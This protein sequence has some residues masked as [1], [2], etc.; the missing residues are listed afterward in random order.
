MTYK[1]PRARD[2]SGN[3]LRS[4]R[5]AKIVADSPKTRPRISKN[6]I[7]YP[8]ELA[9]SATIILPFRAPFYKSIN[10]V[11]HKQDAEDSSKGFRNGFRHLLKY[12]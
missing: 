11:N 3:P 8:P 4:R 7:S 12:F 6:I 10:E 9:M 5:G 1:L 2:S